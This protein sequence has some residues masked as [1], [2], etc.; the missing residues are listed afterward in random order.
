MTKY[1]AE[2]STAAGE[3]KDVLS[4][5]SCA[6]GDDGTTCPETFGAPGEGGIAPISFLIYTVKEYKK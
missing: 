3:G 4:R 6:N 5:S 1:L 2:I